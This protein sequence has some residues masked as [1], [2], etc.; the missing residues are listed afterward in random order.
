GS[1]HRIGKIWQHDARLLEHEKQ[2]EPHLGQHRK[3]HMLAQLAQCIAYL[4]QPG[5]TFLLREQTVARQSG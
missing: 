1:S 4:V 5:L 2:R 3:V